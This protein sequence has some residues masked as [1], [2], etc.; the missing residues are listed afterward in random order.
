MKKMVQGLLIS[1]LVLSAACVSAEGVQEQAMASST[2]SYGTAKNVILLIGDGMAMPQ[3][4]ATE[5]FLGTKKGVIVDPLS[6]EAFPAQGMITTYASD[7]FIT[8]SAA[9]GTALATGSKT[10]CGAISV[11]ESGAVLKNLVEYAQDQDKSTGIVTSTRVT[12]ATPAVFIS[13]NADR[14]AENEIAEDEASSGVDFL[15]GGGY[16]NF[17][18]PASGLSS[19][20]TDGVDLIDQMEAEGYISFISEDETDDFLAWTPRAGQKVVGLFG[21]SHLDYDIDDTDQPSLAEMTE[22]G[23][24]LLSQDD[25]GFFMMI[26]GG[27]IDHACHA[28]DGM[29]AIQDTIAFDDAVKVAIDFYNKNPKDT[30]IVV[31]GDHETGGLTLGFAGT[32]YESAYTLLAGQDTSYEFY[33]YGDFAAYKAS[34]TKANAKVADLAGDL[35]DQFGLTDLNAAETEMLQAALV[36]SISG[37]EVKSTYTDDYLLYG[38]YEP[39]IMTVT[40]ILNNRAGLGWTSYSHTA[41]P[42]GAYALGQGSS[43]FL[44]YYD[45]T[46]V[47]DKI[48]DAM[49][50]Q[51]Q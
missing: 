19:K 27:R 31:T 2:G 41:V 16:R 51:V 50:L 29:T 26:E 38:G 36:R 18:A 37:E 23:I 21:S 48:A 4:S 35:A 47:F 39:F 15:A 45:N 33:Q 32:A 13:H 12:H 24:E 34:H 30:L 17:V 40:H 3:I 44:G 10:Y 28:N 7:R 11:D 49:G 6:F 5:A 22:K 42:L 25:D 14:D 46:N 8:D 9:A 20:R 43:S 1:A